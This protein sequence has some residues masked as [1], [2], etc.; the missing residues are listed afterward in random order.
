M[1]I[2]GAAGRD[3]EQFNVLFRNNPAYEVVAFTAT[4][5]PFISN[6]TYPKEL[7]GKLYPKGIK[8]YDEA[9]LPRLIK[10]LK[11][12][13]C[14]LAYSDL[15][16]QEVM[17]KA[18]IV[19]ACGANFVLAAPQKSMLKSSKPVIAVCAVRTGAG[20][21]PTTRYIS[22]LLRKLGITCVI[23]RH[24]M[25]YGILKDE[26]VERFATLKDLDK[27][28]A[29]IEEREDYEPH[30]KNGFVVYAGVDYEKI[31]RQA[32]REAQVV[33]WDGGNN[34]SSFIKPDLMITVADPLRAG[35]ELSYY[36][37][38]ICARMADVLLINKVN[39]A[40]PGEVERVRS[41]LREVNPSAKV[42]L[43]D[44]VV[45]VDNTKIIRGS[46]VLL[47][48]DGPTIT[49]GNMRFGA[50]TVA[51]EQYGAARVVDAKAYAVGTIKATFDKYKNLEKELPAMGYSTKQIK[52]L[53]TTIN[54]AECDVVISATPTN[55][56]RLINANKPIVQVSYE[57]QPHGKEFDS[58]IEKF[59]KNKVK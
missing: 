27:Y 35:N 14:M 20:K 57:I 15:P 56:R 46:S 26:I 16:Y 48:E 6:R 2:I 29:T 25:P 18:S 36:P 9:E 52:D 50:A 58:L 44:S 42:I 3:F 1:I 59:V 21:S 4:Q 31:L 39:S 43:A 54:R 49:H 30:I 45:S 8:S 28:K 37:G 19:N 41:N 55:L 32:E 24:P 38:E 10:S 47:V 40:D 22:K 5:I 12:D 34:D 13:T 53:E 7:S 23:I 33:I 17:R 11:V 51:A